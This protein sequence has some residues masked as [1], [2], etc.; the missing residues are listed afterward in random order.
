MKK[1]L[2][3]F[4]SIMVGVGI[5]Y[6]ALALNFSDGWAFTLYIVG[7]LGMALALGVFD[8]EEPPCRHMTIAEGLRWRKAA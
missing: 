3:L 5:A 6:G 1:A 2:K 7:A 4:V 8:I